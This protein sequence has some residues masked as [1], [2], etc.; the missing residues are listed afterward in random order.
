MTATE[1][2]LDEVARERLRQ[3]TLKAEGRFRHT[4]A[5]RGMDDG[6]KLACLAEEVGEVAQAVL[7]NRMLTSDGGGDLRTELIHV[8]A[9]GGGRKRTMSAKPPTDYTIREVIVL[10]PRGGQE[11]QWK[12]ETGPYHHEVAAFTTR[13]EALEELARLVNEAHEARS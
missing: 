13:R 8:A 12:I 2:V 6:E 1:H 10:G 11:R 9:I 3:E 5:D 4:C 7:S